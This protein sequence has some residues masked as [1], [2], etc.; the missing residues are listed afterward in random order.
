[1]SPE[2]AS[3]DT[4]LLSGKTEAVALSEIVSM[5]GCYVMGRKR[6]KSNLLITDRDEYKKKGGQKAALQSFGRRL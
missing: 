3:A 5:I 1:V 2:H 6:A 4:R